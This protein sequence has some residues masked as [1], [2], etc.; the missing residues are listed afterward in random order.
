M[1]WGMILAPLEPA[2]A[3]QFNLESKVGAVVVDLDPRSAAAET[4]L[5]VG[6]AI[7]ECNHH[8]VKGPADFTGCAKDKKR[9]LMRIER[10][11]QYFYV[12]IRPGE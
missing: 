11:H 2:L 5:R 12:L 6:D 9:I 4:G 3:R 8:K 7:L 10:A 1:N